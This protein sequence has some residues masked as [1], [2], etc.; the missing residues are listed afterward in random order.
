MTLLGLLCLV[1][2]KSDIHNCTFEL[3][4]DKVKCDVY[5]QIPRDV[6]LN[7]WGVIANGICFQNRIW[8]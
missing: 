4:L 6:M 3:F 8:A 1:H 5:R 2:T 7:I